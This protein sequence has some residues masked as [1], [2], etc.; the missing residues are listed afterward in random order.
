MTVTRDAAART[1]VGRGP[2]LQAIDTAVAALA[3]GQGGAVALVGPGGVGKSRL[4]RE[5]TAIAS[6]RGLTVLSGRAVATGGSTPYR[7]L[8]EAL[9]PWARTHAPG[10]VDLGAHERAYGVL[11]P[12]WATGAAEPLSPVFVAEALLRLLP[13]V[14]GG[15]RTL[16]LLEDLHWADEETLAATEYL[17]DAAESVP[18]LL[19]GTARDD[20]GPGARRTIRALAARGAMRLLRLMPLDAE[21]TR[22]LAEQRL[23]RTPTPALT[24]LLVDRAEGLP[25]FVEEL[26]AALELTGSL[27]IEDDR[28]DVVGLGEQVLPLS[29]ADT[30]SARLEQLT[31]D[32]RRVIEAAALLGRSFDDKLVAAAVGAD[33]A[34][35]LQAATTIGLVHEDP[36]RVGRVRFRHALL[37]DGVLVSTYPPRRVELARSL[38]EQLSTDHLNDD[39]RAVAIELAARAGESAL[40]ARL[41]LRRAMDAFD[42]WAMG[43]AE[44]GLAEA[45]SFAGRDPDLLIEIDML[46]L[47]VASIVGRLDVVMRIGQAL[48]SRLD[49]NGRH[50]QE[51]LDVHLRLAQALLDEAKWQEAK[52]HL[53]QAATLMRVA[54]ACHVTRLELWTAV[55]DWQSRD[56]DS[57]RR[58][59]AH[60]AELARVDED[61]AD[62]VCCALLHEGRAWMPDVETTRARWQEAADYAETHGVRLWQARMLLE[63]ATLEADELRLPAAVVDAQLR[64]VDAIAHE[65]GAVQT[66]TRVALIQARLHLMRGAVDAAAESIALAD[67]RGVA[68]FA[69]RKA[70]ADCVAA[71]ALLRGEVPDEL[72][73]STAVLAALLADDVDAARAAAADA[74]RPAARAALSPLVDLFDVDPRAFG[75]VVDALSFLPDLA[76][77]VARLHEAPLLAALFTHLYASGAPEDR[78]ALHAAV[79]TFDSLG[80][81]KPAD[82]CR[83]LLRT[84]GVP[85]PRRSSS[86]DGVPDQLRA[87]GVTAREFDVLKLLAQGHTNKDVAA[88][89]YLSP[90]TVEKHVER[91]LMKTGA[92]NRTA[93]AALAR[94]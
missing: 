49:R 56:V 39:D 13:H 88:A 20:E 32:Q 79:A 19:I 16:L 80:L 81:T 90:R 91:L 65:C 43:T 47:R 35:A 6:A 93:L 37:R 52:P 5:A 1:I 41:A 58:R 64:E 2:E 46:A 26:L 63:L 40:A 59:A 42:V 57:A 30:V 48:L 71:I 10:D 62:L 83:A 14:S 7:P 28:A 67:A 18:F 51:L 72:T 4:A 87:M 94:A 75:A 53:D 15:A 66:Q 21:T 33:V 31:D 8:I 60:A 85:L 70:R 61:Q 78:D 68:G 23:G 24:S 36:D 34:P 25:L 3:D 50:D 84:A 92:P 17:A 77:A 74:P 89:L 54:D 44:R 55:L 9:A 22:E 27:V 73:P 45:R 38:L 12:G 29:V 76:T 82:A 86:Q 69:S 11:V